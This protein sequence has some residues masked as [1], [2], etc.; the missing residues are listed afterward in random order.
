MLLR[1]NQPNIERNYLVL[2]IG[3]GDNPYYRSDVLVE[4]YIVDNSER[5]SLPII[6]RPFVIASAEKLPFKDK[7]FDFVI[8]RN[9]LEHTDNPD[10]FIKE[11]TRVA[12]R[13][14]LSF[15]T[16]LAE[17]LFGWPFHRWIIDVDYGNSKINM[18]GK[19]NKFFSKTYFQDIFHNLYKNN[20]SFRDFYHKNYSL[21]EHRIEWTKNINYKIIKSEQYLDSQR[22][23]KKAELTPEKII[24][25]VKQDQNLKK[26]F[27]IYGKKIK[28]ILFSNPRKFDFFELLQC[29]KCG[30]ELKKK[31]DIL[32][33]DTC[34]K[35]Y[36]YS[37]I[38]FPVIIFDQQI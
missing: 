24:K 12:K 35:N 8:A 22:A 34:K 2:E 33:C 11:I 19:S 15:P 36:K 13:G 28:K 31:S 38:T 16:T 1:I 21:F 26:S 20:R 25:Y 9:I 17:K 3:S 10:K 7:C 18:T 29:P 23:F 37:N 14:Y 5:I 27:K 4:K 32:F 6:D 30:H